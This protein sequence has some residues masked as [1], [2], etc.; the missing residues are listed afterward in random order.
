MCSY[1]LGVTL[2]RML[3]AASLIAAFLTSANGQAAAVDSGGPA[4]MIVN[5]KG[6]A[7]AVVERRAD[8]HE[9]LKQAARSAT[10][11]RFRIEYVYRSHGTV[12]T[13]PDDPVFSNYDASSD[14]QRFVVIKDVT[15]RD[16]RVTIIQNWYK[17]FEDQTP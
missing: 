15:E 11:E 6:A 12:S 7:V 16:E 8:A 3:L 1:A 14:G 5:A 13:P 4:A 10:S 9:A 2:R 17:E